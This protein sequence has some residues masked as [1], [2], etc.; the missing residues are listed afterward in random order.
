M[1][2]EI[3]KAGMYTIQLDTTQD[4]SVVD[5]YV[6]LLFVMSVVLLFTKD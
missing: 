2:E 5:L 6:R 4:I 3:L 1:S